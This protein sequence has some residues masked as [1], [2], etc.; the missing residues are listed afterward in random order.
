MAVP[1]PRILAAA[2]LSAPGQSTPTE[3]PVS[4]IPINPKIGDAESEIIRYA[5]MQK[6]L[7]AYMAEKQDKKK[8]KK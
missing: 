5:K 4:A 3:N 7:D 8:K 1:P 6:K 2:I